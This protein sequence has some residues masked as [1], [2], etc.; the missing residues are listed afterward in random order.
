MAEHPNVARINDVYA[1]MGKGDL[2]ALHDM[3]AEDLVW[4][5]CG[6]NQLSGDYRGR[7]GVF[8]YFGK[9]MEVTEGSLHIELHSVLADDEHGVALMTISATR[10]QQSLNVNAVDVMHLHDGKV[11]EVW[12]IP[13]DQY[14]YDEFIG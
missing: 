11:A 4:H 10:G 9:V 3:F 14:T 8:Q 5:D 1:A 6:R 2:A 13:T 12:A 7:E